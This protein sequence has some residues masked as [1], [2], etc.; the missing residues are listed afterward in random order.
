MTSLVKRIL[1]AVIAIPLLIVI[2]TCLPQYNYLA[3]ALVCLVMSIIGSYEMRAIADKEHQLH[4]IFPPWVGALLPV[5]TYI[6]KA[7]LP[8]F[9]LTL[10]G[11]VGILS[12][13]FALE[14]FLG[15]HDNF[16][17]SKQRLE[18]YTLEIVY[19]N[20]LATFLIRMCFLQNAW[21]WILIF[22]GFVFGS[23]TFAYLFGIWLGK[24]NR[25]I[26]KVS[27]NKSIAGF[28]FGLLLPALMGL[29]FAISF[30]VI[31]IKWYQGLILGFFTA[32]AGTCGDLIESTF[33]RSANIKDSGKVIPGRGG[34]LDSIDS[35]LI[36]APIFLLCLY[37][38]GI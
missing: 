33:K 16:K 27:P 3:F 19:P 29:L 21:A 9:N 1:T 14:A 23:D 31:A 10:F 24:N 20:L 34:V 17:G 18:T 6:E 15:Y 26:I 35:I 38:F 8:Q 5:I 32:L 13:G 25:G 4:L 28:I 12:F 11:F 22:L 36:A 7:F 30:D 2:I 37:T